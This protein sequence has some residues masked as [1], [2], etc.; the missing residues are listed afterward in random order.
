VGINV[1]KGLRSVG[2]PLLSILVALFLGGIILALMGYDV[3]AAYASQFKGAF[4]DANAIGETMVQMVPLIFCALSYAVAYRC[5]L[6]NLGAEGQLYIGAIL[7]ALVGARVQGLPPAAHILLCL[8]AG[9]V[10][11][12]LMGC[13]VGALKTRFGASELITTIMLNYIAMEFVAWCV[14]NVPFKDLTPGAAPRMPAVLASARLPIILPGTRLHLGIVLAVVGIAGYYFFMWRTTRGYEMR[15][16]G[17]NQNAGR[18]SGMNIRANSVLAMTIAGG[19]A[20]LAGVTQIIGL[21]FFLTEG[22]SNNFGF[23]GIA[24]ALLGSCHPVGIGVSAILFGALNAGGNKMQLLASVPAASIYM[25]QGMIILFAISRELF[26]WFGKGGGRVLAL[27]RRPAK[28]GG[29]A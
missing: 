24:V 4:G 3:G 9:F 22:F 17:M 13:L 18:Y 2:F 23:S 20:G 5:G 26:L 25:I 1:K 12:G 28:D 27:A 29:G 16:I 21:Q 15:V 7:G 14:N 8:V 10:G 11:G 19:Y 6:I